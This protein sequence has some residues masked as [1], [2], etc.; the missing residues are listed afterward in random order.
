MTKKILTLFSI[1]IVFSCSNNDQKYMDWIGEKRSTSFTDDDMSFLIKTFGNPTDTIQTGNEK[2]FGFT[3][4]GSFYGPSFT[5]EE[6]ESIIN[7]FNAEKEKLRRKIKNNDDYWDALDALRDNYENLYY[8]K[9]GED[10]YSFND[11]LNSY[12][13]K[14]PEV[15]YDRSVEIIFDV[16]GVDDNRNYLTRPYLSTSYQFL[17]SENISYN[18]MYGGNNEDFLID[19]YKYVIVDK[20]GI[21]ISDYTDGT[22]CISKV[23][24]NKLKN[25]TYGDWVYKGGTD[26]VLGAFKFND[27]GTYSYSNTMG[28]SKR[29]KWWITCGGEISMTNSDRNIKIVKNGIRVGETTYRK[30]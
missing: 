26:R 16:I 12:R 4:I 19:V 5:K 8:E 7:N 22:S 18:K 29:G 6:S 28:A 9:V 30:L 20:K 17:I 11:L 2:K 3:N 27:D 14:K 10:K 24:I 15:S 1:I 13:L 23:G 25:K 21:I